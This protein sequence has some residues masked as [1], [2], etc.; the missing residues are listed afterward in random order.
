MVKCIQYGIGSSCEGFLHES[1][2][3]G[4]PEMSEYPGDQIGAVGWCTDTDPQPRKIFVRELGKNGTHAIVRARRA[5]FAQPEGTFGQINVVIDDQQMV[6]RTMIP[7]QQ[8][9]HAFTACVHKC[10]R[11][12]QDNP[13]AVLPDFSNQP[14][15]PG[16]CQRCGEVAGQALDDFKA[17]V[18][19]CVCVLGTGVPETDNEKGFQMIG[20]KHIYLEKPPGHR[21]SGE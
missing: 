3:L 2:F 20:K 17:T 18:M 21:P 19:P 15:T 11:L 4:C 1:G 16:T 13:A 5:G 12:T 7:V 6:C 9:G 10:L 14:F 8:R